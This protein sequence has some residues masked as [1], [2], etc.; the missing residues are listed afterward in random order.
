ML[1][2]G[3]AQGI[4]SGKILSLADPGRWRNGSSAKTGSE[5]CWLRK[6]LSPGTAVGFLCCTPTKDTF[7]AAHGRRE[8]QGESGP[9]TP[10][11]LWQKEMLPQ[12]F[13]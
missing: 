13:H 1:R 3:K 6:K 8:A 12:G 10:K 4:N 5:W 2:L 9:L 7:L 11:L